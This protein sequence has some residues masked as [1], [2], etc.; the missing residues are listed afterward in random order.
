MVEEFFTC[1]HALLYWAPIPS[2][3]LWV[4]IAVIVSRVQDAG[5]LA[6]DKSDDN[7]MYFEMLLRKYSQVGRY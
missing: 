6:A 5:T 2:S 4:F 1:R 7:H 3:A